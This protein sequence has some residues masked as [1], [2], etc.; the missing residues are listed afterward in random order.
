M[1][2]RS[3]WLDKDRRYGKTTVCNKCGKLFHKGKWQIM[4]IKDIYIIYTTHLEMPQVSPK[5]FDNI[6]D[7]EYFYETMIQNKQNGKWLGFQARYT[8]TPDAIEGHWLAYDKLED[9][10]LNPDK[11]PQGIIEMFADAMQAANYQE[12]KFSE[13]TKKQSI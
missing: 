10:I 1:Q 4:S 13:K 3:V 9:M 7:S 12:N 11:Y 2:L 6:M 8:N 5:L